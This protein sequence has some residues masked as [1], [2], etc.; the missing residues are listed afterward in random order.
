[1]SE[2]KKHYFKVPKNINK[3]TDE[4]L[5]AFADEIYEELLKAFESDKKYEG[6]Q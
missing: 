3:M 1:M 5:S 4:Q 2:F 6:K